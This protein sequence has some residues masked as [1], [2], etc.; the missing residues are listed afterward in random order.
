M[1]DNH[2]YLQLLRNGTQE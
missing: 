2:L 1:I